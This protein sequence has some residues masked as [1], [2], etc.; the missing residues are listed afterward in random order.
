MLKSSTVV[1]LDVALIGGLIIIEI[2]TLI[3]RHLR[4]VEIGGIFQVVVIPGAGVAEILVLSVRIVQ[5]LAVLR[6]VV[7]ILLS[8]IV[9]TLLVVAVLAT[10]G[11]LG[12]VLPH[13]R[14][15]IEIV[16]TILH[17][18]SIVHVVAILK[19]ALVAVAVLEV[20]LLIAAVGQVVAVFHA[21]RETLALIVLLL[22]AILQVIVVFVVL[23]L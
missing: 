22:L 9:Q 8:G 1:R 12:K 11:A 13:A 6:V 20:I 7:Q 2:R 14:I 4:G 16:V 10:T 3:G 5:A 15:G 23:Q 18:A 21:V 17:A 19:A